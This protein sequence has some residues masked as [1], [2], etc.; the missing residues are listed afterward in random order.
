MTPLYELRATWLDMYVHYVCQ[1]T[2]NEDMR[3]QLALF[4]YF[5]ILSGARA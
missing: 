3:Y 1:S 4:Y 5:L 2:E